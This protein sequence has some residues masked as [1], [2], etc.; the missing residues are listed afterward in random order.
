MQLPVK[1]KIFDKETNAY[2][3]NDI[4][5]YT[6][7]VSKGGLCLILPRSWDCPECNNCLGW[8]YNLTCKLKNN[9]TKDDNHL[10]ASKLSLKISLSDPS[11]PGKEP[12]QLEGNCVWVNSDI[13]QQEN[14]Y[15]VGVRLPDAG[16]KRISSF[17]SDVINP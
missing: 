10:L 3:T 4:E 15:S 1:M 7:N 8:I 5:V 17:L 6:E 2:I 9:H 12:I 14:S 13:P 11:V 16:Q